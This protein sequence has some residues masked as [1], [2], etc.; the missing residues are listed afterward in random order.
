MLS[1]QTNIL[2]WEADR[3]LGIN[4]KKKTKATEKLA[5]G[6]RINR[7]A[8]DAAGLAISE[9]MRRQIRGL[10][11]GA[12]NIQD[13]IGYVQTADGALNEVHDMLHRMNELAV[14]S[15]NGTNSKE[16]REYIDKEIQ[17]I[18]SEMK[19]VFD[20]TTFNKRKIWEPDQ[21]KIIGYEKRQAVEFQNTS[22]NIDATND[23]CG[24]VAADSYK[25]HAG[26]DGVYVDWKGYDGQTYK[27]EAI[28]W[29]IL[30]KNNYSFEMS[31]YFGAADGTNKLYDANGNPVFKHQVSF[32]PQETATVDDIIK[33]IDGKA[34]SGYGSADM[35]VQFE[36][37]SGGRETK[38]GVSFPY[39]SLSYNAAY[40][41]NHNTG[42]DTSQS[43]NIF[44]FDKADDKFLE[45]ADASKTLVQIQGSGSNLIS[46]PQKTGS[47]AE[48]KDSDETWT[49]S[50]YMDGIGEVKAVSNSV[51]YYAPSDMADDDETYWWNWSYYYVN[52]VQQRYRAYRTISSSEKGGGTL[53]SVMAALTGEKGTKTPG[54]LAK[55]N[56]GDCDNGGYI[57]LDFALR[58]TEQYT[59]GDNKKSNVVG[60]Y[61]MRFRVNPD[62]TEETVLNRIKNALNDNTILDFYTPS[63]SSYYGSAYFGTAYA[64]RY[65]IDAPLYGG[66]CCLRVQAGAEAGQCIDIEYESLNIIGM[67]LQNTNVLTEAASRKAIDEIKKGVQIISEQ[68]AVFGAYQNRLE[69]AYNDNLN[70]V[71]N[72]QAA[73]SLIRDTDMA[74]TMVEYSNNHILVQAGTSM[75]TQANQQ[76]NRIL[77]L[78]Q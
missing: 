43:K 59:Y 51:S 33:C 69:H 45:P 1:I 73:E 30:K 34:F 3:Q 18:K 53:G 72:T 41:S 56:G 23:N 21:K 58:S 76:V 28:D 49:F 68:R 2:A 74:K 22:A 20:T 44:D 5:S 6:Y 55:A 48:A 71:E 32:T 42:V 24:V 75:L 4:N 46:R 39:V 10:R 9:K 50:F 66:L 29:D 64:T 40:A 15:A 67:G 52:G 63:G 26:Q 25:I 35:E 11:Q 36:N 31:D 14:K 70:V 27:T 57:D 60:S 16:D 17:A 61:T 62:D 13:G 19:R 54:L 78:L 77:Q 38:A 47:V 37:I 65:A 7:A 12:E 8:D